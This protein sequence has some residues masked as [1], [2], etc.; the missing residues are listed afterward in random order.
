MA[1]GIYVVVTSAV[2]AERDQ[3]FNRWYDRV[4]FPQVLE[5]DGI[6]SARRFKVASV[7]AQDGASLGGDDQ[8][9]VI[10]ELDGDFEAL[11]DEIA[12]RS[13]DGTFISRSC[14]KGTA[15][16]GTQVRTATA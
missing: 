1:R 13:T 16:P 12:K 15:W 3:A 2:S 9:L 8:Y 7:Q 5:I 4:H 10:Y 14:T 6:L 11:A